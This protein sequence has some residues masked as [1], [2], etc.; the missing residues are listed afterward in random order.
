MYP[1]IFLN[2]P[3]IYSEPGKPPRPAFEFANRT[4]T[5]AAL[6]EFPILR[7]PRTGLFTGQKLKL[8]NPDRVIFCL[9]NEVAK[10]RFL[11][12][13]RLKR[14]SSLCRNSFTY[15]PRSWAC[16]PLHRWRK[17]PPPCFDTLLCNHCSYK[18]AC[19]R[20]ERDATFPLLFY[21]SFQIAQV[22]TIPKILVHASQIRSQIHI[23]VTFKM[24][25]RYES[26]LNFRCDC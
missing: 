20:V 19:R 8:R 2:K 6:H 25:S 21:R 14:R 5:E 7:N 17:P 26:A 12:G 9:E 22:I 18:G 15:G 4:Y 23:H 1:H 24:S 11:L 3:S 16:N 13:S 10:Y